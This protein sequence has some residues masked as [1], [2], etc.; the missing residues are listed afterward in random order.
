[1]W[2]KVD[3]KSNDCCLK[4]RRERFRYRDTHAKGR[5]VR[6]DGGRDWS[7][8]AIN[9]TEDCWQ[10]QRQEKQGGILPLSLQGAWPTDIIMADFW[11]P[12][13]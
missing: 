7:E 2:V 12:G 9:N 13:Q 8:A 5:L 1:M 11:P 10:H 4:K 3:P 6:D